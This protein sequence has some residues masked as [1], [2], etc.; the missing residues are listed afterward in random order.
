MIK[1]NSWQS[2]CQFLKE[3]FCCFKLG[4]G[5]DKIARLYQQGGE[6]LEKD[7]DIRS[8]IKAVKSQRIMSKHYLVPEAIRFKIKHSV[9]NVIDLDKE[10]SGGD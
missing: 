1:V 5:R 10:Q 9:E 8:L 4:L 3:L 6:R 2:A 7:F